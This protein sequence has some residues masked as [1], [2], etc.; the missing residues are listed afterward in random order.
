MKKLLP[1]ALLIALTGCFDY[2]DGDRAGVVNKLS[3]KG[4]IFK[5]WEGEMN[6]G[7]FRNQANAATGQSTGA[8]TANIFT[9]TVEDEVVVEKL[10]AAMAEGRVVSLTYRQELIVMPWRGDTNYFI[11]NV[12]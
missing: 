12:R 6:L 4:I 1:L 11:T 3:R 2:S 10:R 9:F 5:T 8:M 7:G